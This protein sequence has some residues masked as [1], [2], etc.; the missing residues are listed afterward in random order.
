VTR[1]HVVDPQYPGTID[2]IIN[3]GAFWD[4][5]ALIEKRADIVDLTGRYKACFENAY[6]Y[7]AAAKKF[8]DDTT[9]IILGAVHYERLHKLTQRIIKKELKK[10]NHKEG[11][12]KK[13]FLSGITPYGIYPYFAALQAQNYKV[14]Q[15]NDEYHVASDMLR[16]ISRTAVQYG[17]TAYACYCPFSPDTDIEHLILPE[18]KLAF[19]TSNS[20][21]AYTGTAFRT[22]NLNRYLEPDII[23]LRR[24]RIRFNKKVLDSILENAI[25]SIYEAKRYHDKLEEYY[26]PHMRFMQINALTQDLKTQISQI[27]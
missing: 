14:Y 11:I 23:R 15:L 18:C 27:S 7:L 9:S 4:T 24:S 8:R 25:Y 21:H 5:A 17:L 2:E 1:S 19:V 13:R 26:T 3:L 10:T 22:I 20:Y 16:E 6:R 12:L